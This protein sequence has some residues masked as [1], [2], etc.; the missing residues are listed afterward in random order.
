[1]VFVK[2]LAQRLQRVAPRKMREPARNGT[3]ARQHRLEGQVHARYDA[4]P[5]TAPNPSSTPSAISSIPP[6]A[7]SP[8]APDPA[9]S[10]DALARRGQP[11]RADRAVSGLGAGARAA[12]AGR[13]VARAQGA[14]LVHPACGAD[15]R[16]RH[17]APGNRY[18]IK[19]RT[20]KRTE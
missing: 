8:A 9:A 14:A 17:H 3:H 7:A 4:S 18:L 10:R 16:A 19:L 15:E 13:L 11:A 2:A 6:A 12:A 20:R 5:M 1:V